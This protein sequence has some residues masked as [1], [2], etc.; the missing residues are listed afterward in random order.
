MTKITITTAGIKA[1]LFAASLIP[2]FLAVY[3]GLTTNV[4]TVV[5]SSLFTITLL[6]HLYYGYK[7]AKYAATFLSLLFAVTQF[8]IFKFSISAQG[9]GF[10]FL[11]LLLIINS[12][13]LLRSKAVADFLS[14]QFTE[15]SKNA[16][17]FLKLTRWLLLV[18]V[19]IALAK[20]L[21]K[22]AR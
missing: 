22:L 9:L 3:M 17:L 15:R 18:I 13:L 21:I 19:V 8:F 12:L 16:L 10:G 1:I 20:D 6:L 7:W 11:C 5:L 14:K 2:L 4:L